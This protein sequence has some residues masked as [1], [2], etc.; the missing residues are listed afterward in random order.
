MA[1]NL[2]WEYFTQEKETYPAWCERARVA[3]L[4]WL[5]RMWDDKGHVMATTFIPDPENQWKE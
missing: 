3:S 4:G 1:V 2:K 5:V